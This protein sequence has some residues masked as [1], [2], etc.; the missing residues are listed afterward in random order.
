MDCASC[1]TTT[2]WALSASGSGTA[3]GA[4]GPAGFAPGGGVEGATAV[5]DLRGGDAGGEPVGVDVGE[6]RPFGHVRQQVGAVGGGDRVVDVVEFGVL[7]AGVVEGLGVCDGD[8]G[9]ELVQP[10]CGGEGG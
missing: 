3:E 9:A 10:L 6:V 1:R 2:I 8:R 4:E 7:L 5:D